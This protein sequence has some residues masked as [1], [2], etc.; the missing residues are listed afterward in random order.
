[1][2]YLYY[3]AFSRSET[4]SG[5]QTW[6]V[7]FPDFDYCSTFGYDMEEALEMA[8]DI[9]ALNLLGIEDN[10]EPLPQVSSPEEVSVKFKDYLAEIGEDVNEFFMVVP[11]QVN[12][13]LHRIK[14]E[15]DYVKRSVTLPKYL[16][17]LGKDK[18]INFSQMLQLALKQHLNVK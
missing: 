18:G 1:M 4:P 8:E 7:I 14:Q 5:K 13:V 12:T 11:V 6:N 3:G 16:D 2:N 9:L 15:N 10:N 17:A